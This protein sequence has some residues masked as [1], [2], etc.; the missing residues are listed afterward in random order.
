MGIKTWV[1]C[2][3]LLPALAL[4]DAT[5]SIRYYVDDSGVDFETTGSATQQNT[6]FAI[7]SIGKTMT[8]VAVLRVVEQGDID[9]DGA[10][11]DWVSPDIADG[12]GD[13][14]EISVRHLLNM[15]SGLPDY[16]SDDYIEDALSDPDRIQTP[17]MALT[18]AYGEPQVFGVG[19]G[20]DYSNTNYVLL[21]LILEQATGQTYAETLRSEV[22]VPANMTNSFAFGSKA[23]PASFPSGHEDGTHY[24]DYYE[25]LGFGDG[26]VISTAPDL[27]KFYQAL[28]ISGDLLSDALVDEMLVDPIGEGYGMGIEVE[29]NIVGHSGGDLGFS[30]DV[31]MDL[32]DGRIAII[33]EASDDADTSW[34]FGRLFD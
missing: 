5:Q 8:A 21:G 12:L 33:F 2:A 15:T 1:A 30:S 11:S 10:V 14:R 13:L 19:Q 17:R 28:F 27:A 7:A 22:F 31:R 32:D 34:T 20:F 18:Y 9:L 29:D 6:P 4:A 26:G 24:R 25:N 3:I 16:L 23:L